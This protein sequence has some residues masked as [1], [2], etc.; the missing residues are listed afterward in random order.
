MDVQRGRD[1]KNLPAITL[2]KSH[3]D[4]K[5]KKR[6]KKKEIRKSRKYTQEKGAKIC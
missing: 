3:D 2:L 4:A 5:N 6:N 1:P